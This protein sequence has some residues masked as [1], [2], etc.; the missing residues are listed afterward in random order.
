V[1]PFKL[2]AIWDGVIERMEKRLASWKK[3]YLSKGGRLTLIKSTLSSLPTY[4]LSL[5]PL[6][7]GIAR[8][9][10]L[11]QRDFLWDGPGGDLEIHRVNWKRVSDPISSGGWALKS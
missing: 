10:E 4:F 3:I 11:L 2:G 5:F 9:M 1:P 8:Q 6:P 7:A